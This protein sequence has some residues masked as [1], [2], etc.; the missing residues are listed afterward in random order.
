[1][2]NIVTFSSH[3]GRTWDVAVWQITDSEGASRAWSFDEGQGDQPDLEGAREAASRI[4]K[5]ANRAAEIISRIRLLFKKGTSQ[6]E[7]V[8]MNEIIR[9]MVAL[10]GS[11]VTRHS[12]SVRTELAED[13]PQIMGDRV[14]MQQVFMN[15]MINGVDAMKDMDGTRELAIKSQR[16]END[17]L[18]MSSAIPALG[19]PRTGGPDLQCVLYH[20]AS[21]HRHGSSDQPLHH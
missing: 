12:I 10:M 8:D 5:D 2:C 6:W 1:M 4:V 16:A 13:I 11:E 17:Q 20:E 15:L 14:Q 3:F 18:M 19:C 7:L 21:W 9:E